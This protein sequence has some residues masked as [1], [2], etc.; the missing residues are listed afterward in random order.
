M[1]AIVAEKIEIQKQMDDKLIAIKKEKMIYGSLVAERMNLDAQ[2]FATFG[3]QIE[4]QISKTKDAI[5][6]MDQLNAKSGGGSAGIA[7][8]RANG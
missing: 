4:M 1:L 7:G 8:A 5:T 3:Q 6:L 2:Y